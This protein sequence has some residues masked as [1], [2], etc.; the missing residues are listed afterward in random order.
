VSK[1]GRTCAWCLERRR[2]GT[3]TIDYYKIAN[4]SAETIRLPVLHFLTFIIYNS[5]CDTWSTLSINCAAKP[6][7]LA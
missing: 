3:K 1:P 4:Q 5:T 7:A 6:P 2:A